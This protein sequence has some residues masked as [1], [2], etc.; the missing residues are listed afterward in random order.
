MKVPFVDQVS[1]ANV[2]LNATLV[3]CN[4]EHLFDI[5]TIFMTNRTSV[6]I[7]T[8]IPNPI[9]LFITLAQ[10]IPLTL[11]LLFIP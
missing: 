10:S 11:F 6:H 7:S 2:P 4:L 5:F 9:L 1:E 3:V 8:F